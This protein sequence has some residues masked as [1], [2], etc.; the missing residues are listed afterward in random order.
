[1]VINLLH[2]D[3][4][5]SHSNFELRLDHGILLKNLYLN[6]FLLWNFLNIS[7]IG[8]DRQ[9]WHPM[10]DTLRIRAVVVVAVLIQNALR[11]LEKKLTPK[12]N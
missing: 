9:W 8:N 2:D 10:V 4:V 1:M 6:N 7:S 12:Q 11:K 3:D 5:P